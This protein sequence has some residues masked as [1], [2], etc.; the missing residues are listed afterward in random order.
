ML[1]EANVSSNQ[2]TQVSLCCKLT[3]FDKIHA[4]VA[5]KDCEK[6]IKKNKYNSCNIPIPKDRQKSISRE[7]VIRSL[8]KWEGTSEIQRLAISFKSKNSEHGENRRKS[9]CLSYNDMH[10]DIKE[11]VKFSL[12]KDSGSTASN[13]LI[14]TYRYLSSQSCLT[15]IFSGYVLVTRVLIGVIGKS[16][17]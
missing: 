8:Y 13:F 4:L 16:R 10:M 12:C 3:E 7:S 14:A 6:K 9:I 17:K 1:F 15:R 2:Q 5:L 11:S